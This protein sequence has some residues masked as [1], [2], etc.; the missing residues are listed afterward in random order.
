[1]FPESVYSC[2]CRIK[3]NRVSYLFIGLARIGLYNAEAEK[4]AYDCHGNSVYET[5]N[6]GTAN[7]REY[8]RK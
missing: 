3:K 2:S 1:M 4:V 5:E 8:T 7:E 6:T